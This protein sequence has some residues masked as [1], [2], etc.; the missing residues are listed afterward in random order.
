MVEQVLTNPAD[1]SK[2]AISQTD[3]YSLTVGSTIYYGP[4]LKINST[5]LRMTPTAYKSQ[6]QLVFT[7][8]ELH[9]PESA[10]FFAISSIT[11]V[12]K[13]NES[14]PDDL[15]IINFVKPQDPESSYVDLSDKIDEY[16]KTSQVQAF[17]FK[18]GMV[19]FAKASTVQG[20]FLSGAKHV[21]YMANNGQVSLT[22]AKPD[23]YAS[24]TS[25]ELLYWQNLKSSSQVAKAI[26]V[27][28]KNNP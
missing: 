28:E 25:N 5:F 9:G 7:G 4:I 6:G 27:Y 1:K 23:Q 20:N 17:F 8:N 19:L 2:V 10:T 24:R 21:Y 26:V 3:Y 22:V 15:A 14:S 11:D 13:L 12:H 18:D 16:L